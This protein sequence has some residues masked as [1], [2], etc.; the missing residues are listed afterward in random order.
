M[1]IPHF[2]LSV[3]LPVLCF[4]YL[5]LADTTLEA[6]GGLDRRGEMSTLPSQKVLWGR[7]II[8]CD[9]SWEGGS[10]LPKN[11]SDSGSVVSEI[12]RYTQTEKKHIDTV[13]LLK[14]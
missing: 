6:I 10:T 12:L 7:F 2:S 5:S 13:T 4:F 8:R 1:S 14:E 11:S 9:F 3:S